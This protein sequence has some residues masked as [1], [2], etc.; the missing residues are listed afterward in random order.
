MASLIVNVYPKI[1][2]VELIHV[3]IIFTV[4]VWAILSELC[5]T[6]CVSTTWSLNV[7]CCS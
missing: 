2:G 6:H 1:N 4:P 7:S 5:Q 3:G